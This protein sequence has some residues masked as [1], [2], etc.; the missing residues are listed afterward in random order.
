[1][2]F[3]QTAILSLVEGLTEFLPVS[4]TGH[5]ILTSHLLGLPATEMQKSFEIAIQSG[6]I[7]AVVVLYARR[8]L[9][10]RRTMLLVFTAFLPTAVI[11]F[12]VHGIVKELLLGNVVV[13][14]WSLLLGGAVLLIFEI[15]RP[16]SSSGADIERM[17]FT[18]AAVVGVCQSVAIIPGVSRSAATI[19]GGELLGIR[20]D[21][22]VEF[23][24]L[25]A[26]PTMAA[27]TGLDLVKSAS[28][29]TAADIQSI[30][31][32]VVLSF[33]VS[34]MA[35][36]W[37]L[38]YVKTHSFAVFGMYRIALAALFWMFFLR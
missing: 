31:V 15:L 19:I 27:A 16:D 20:R 32:G 10:D 1:M 25:L 33:F 28:S 26:I 24:F 3:F 13:V 12:L 8:L 23:S 6:A 17:S 14:L 21:A 11:G 34:L 38:S 29:F 37:F 5:L 2:T 22:I 35:V 30:A 7:L 36:R 18:Q 9:R 4:S